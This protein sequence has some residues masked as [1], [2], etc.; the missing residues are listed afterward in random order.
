MGRCS[1]KQQTRASKMEPRPNRA[2]ADI[3]MQVRSISQKY[4]NNYP[5]QSIPTHQHAFQ[6]KPMTQRSHPNDPDPKST[7]L[8]IF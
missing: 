1:I 2:K 7:K 3:L 6:M 8:E 4:H 5:F